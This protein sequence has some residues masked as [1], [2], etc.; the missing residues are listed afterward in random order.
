MEAL[1]V[2]LNAKYIHSCLAVR[3]LRRTAGASVELYE[4]NINI[5]AK[6]HFRAL[7]ER[8]AKG[9]VIGFSTYIWN[10][11][12]VT[13]LC[14]VLKKTRPDITLLLGGP[15]CSGGA[16]RL[17]EA[18]GAH[19]A[20]SGEGEA[21]FAAF[22]A[23]MRGEGTAADVPG[24]WYKAEGLWAHNAEAETP[25]ETLAFAYEGEDLTGRTAYY[26]SSRGCPFRCAFCLS[27]GV[28]LRQ[29]PAARAWRELTRLADMGAKQVK[30]V[31][32][33]FNADPPRAREIWGALIRDFGGKPINF[34][35]EIA[36]Q[37]LSGEDFA[38]LERAPKGLFQFE[39]GIQSTNPE[40]L[41][42]INRSGNTPAIFGAVRRL[43]AMGNIHVHVDLIAGLPH[44]G[45]ERF[46]QTFDAVF[47]LN[48]DALQLGFLKLL[49]GSD[50][51]ERAD[52]LGI[53]YDDKPPYAALKTSALPTEALLRLGRL[54]RA[55]V[56]TW[57]ERFH[58][59]MRVLLEGF[60][61]PFALFCALGDA[62]EDAPSD[63]NAV[64]RALHGFIRENGLLSTRLLECMKFDL[65][66]REKCWKPPP[67]LPE[68]HEKDKLFA[69]ERLQQ[70]VA[71]ALP[72]TAKPYS[73]N[74][75]LELFQFDV[76]GDGSEAPNWILFSYAPE[77]VFVKLDLSVFL[78]KNDGVL[79]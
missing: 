42:E 25:M 3:L 5:P 50:L 43:V 73:R 19:Y 54:E 70:A 9:A 2:A 47:A 20:I 66:R 55:F 38:I 65:L 15:E 32:R 27:A 33:T 18:S 14:S 74:A 68:M 41:R 31:D 22:L 21:P 58:A 26:E 53:V 61:S 1:L 69:R 78:G 30:L 52:E 45:F 8:A 67:F 75:H 34:H 12:T 7:F 37:L 13:W 51:R 11:E 62:W 6:A 63:P 39:I 77:R 16:E 59:T 64:L 76:A 24:L 49:P 44:E 46:G 36:A 57:N 72:Q 10:V 35:F 79:I 40:T 17:L 48:A 56:R 28:K 71:G 29:H 4:S 23:F 60:P